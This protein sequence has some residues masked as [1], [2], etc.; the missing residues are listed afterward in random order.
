M[1]RKLMLNMIDAH[2]HLMDFRYEYAPKIPVI[3]TGYDLK[4]SQRA[5]ES[6]RENVWAVVGISPQKSMRPLETSEIE[7]IEELG[8]KAVG[9]GEIGL[10]YHWGKEEIE[11]K[12]QEIWFRAQIRVANELGLPIVIHARDASERVFEILNR[13]FDGV[14]MFH[15]YSGDHELAKRIVDKGW[16]V[17]IPPLRS[18]KRKKVISSVPLENIVAETDAP[19]VGK[20]CED[21]FKS[22]SY[23]A[24]IKET[25]LEEVEK[26]TEKST[27]RIFSI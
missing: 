1:I 23:V 26:T 15:F 14:V 16:Y 5:V 10:D 17:S 11:R 21:V 18:K 13:E 8:K 12:H 6:I 25:S 20:V 3:N 19:Y 22:M 9:I 4:T 7:K 27:R 24:E 2:A